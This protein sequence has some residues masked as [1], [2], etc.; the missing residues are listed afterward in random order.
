MGQ[1]WLVIVLRE[2]K[3]VDKQNTVSYRIQRINT[4]SYTTKDKYMGWTD[5]TEVAML[6]RNKGKEIKCDF[7]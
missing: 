3:T 6:D 7:C 4:I 2:L 5:Q 1:P